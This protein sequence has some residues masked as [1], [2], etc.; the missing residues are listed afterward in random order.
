MIEASGW[1]IVAD[2]REWPESVLMGL[3]EVVRGADDVWLVA[4]IGA[5][6]L[7]QVPVPNATLLSVAESVSFSAALN[8]AVVVSQSPVVV[9]LEE[10]ATVSLGDLRDG[11]RSTVRT[12]S[13]TL[14][15][16]GTEP[17]G[18]WG[19]SLLTPIARDRWT[20]GTAVIFDR[21]AFLRIQGFDETARARTRPCIDLAERLR[22]VGCS[23]QWR[24]DL[25]TACVAVDNTVRLGRAEVA[26]IEESVRADP[27][28]VRNLPVWSSSDQNSPLVSV[29]IAT[30]NRAAFLR[31]S[32]SS[33][34]AQ[35]FYNFE[36]LVIDDGSDDET[37]DV[38]ASVAGTDPRV[39]YIRQEQA[40][41]AGARNRGADESRGFYTAVH[42]DDD[43]M[44]PWRLEKGLGALQEQDRAT[45]GAWVN[46]D[47][48]SA[49]MITHVT[50]EEFGMPVSLHNG[51][52]PG[53]ATWLIE[54]ELL[55]RFRYDE[56]MTSAVDH[57]LALRLMRMG[58]RWRHAGCVMFLRRMHPGQVSVVDRTSQ[59]AGA[60]LSRLMLESGTSVAS[61]DKVRSR[62]SE[63]RWPTIPGRSEPQR[64]FAAYLPDHLVER[65][66]LLRGGA[67][68]KVIAVNKV[69][70]TGVVILERSLD[71]REIEESAEVDDVTL[72]DLARLRTAGIT[73][74]VEARLRPVEGVPFP[75]DRLRQALMRVAARLVA[76]SL[77]DGTG[78]LEAL[79][80]APD[81]HSTLLSAVA[82]EYSH[83][84]FRRVHVSAS[85]EDRLDVTLIGFSDRRTALRAFARLRQEPDGSSVALVGTEQLVLDP[86][87]QD[88]SLLEEKA[89]VDAI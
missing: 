15:S 17:S 9:V 25:S 53:H 36:L 80:M 2:V 3:L 13:V 76:R 54:T 47:N 81:R 84:V 23:V 71:G 67:L 49:E 50:R 75:Q 19:R 42:D 57:N 8:A 89:A 20:A 7:V 30:R 59:D 39:R 78:S 10:P 58:V 48:E 24:E 73:F 11:V 61:A 40:G 69:S 35:T 46:F 44:L 85:S 5:S 16:Y 87:L 65:R 52:S 33:V 12:E 27:S 63:T 70:D 32:I 6:P 77:R 72:A 41:I 4:T 88:L 66:V 22:R 56:R 79:V 21:A 51:Q 31:D 29:V 82:G 1:T 60:R 45:Y 55:R 86:L 28:I 62:Q 34:L 26:L 43:I 64:H 38:V 68:N 14:L 74:E 37:P 18:G 83:S